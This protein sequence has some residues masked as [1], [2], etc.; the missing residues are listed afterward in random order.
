MADYTVTENIEE[1]ENQ[2]RIE[3]FKGY[4]IEA[5]DPYGHYSIH[6]FHGML[7]DVLKGSYTSAAMARAKI[8]HYLN[9]KVPH[10]QNKI[11]DAH[12]AKLGLKTEEVEVNG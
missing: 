2:D 8:E 5:K 11:N 7:P 12:R 4:K 6:Q 9:T 1:Y 10:N 3:I